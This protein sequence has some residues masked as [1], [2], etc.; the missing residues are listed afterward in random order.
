MMSFSIDF[1]SLNGSL[2]S[3]YLGRKV[4]FRLMA[5][6]NYRSTEE[7]F[8]VLLM[9]DGQDFKAMDLEK[10]IS[11]SYLNRKIRPFV[12]VGI[13]TNEN[14]LHEYGTASSGDFK[15]R[16]K[17]ANNYSKFIIE[18][19]IPFLK[20][21]FKVSHH[22]IDWVYVGMSLGGISAFDIVYNNPQYFSKVGVF[23]GSFWWRKK[24]Y[25]KNDMADRSRIIL[26]V[27][28][29]GNYSP[30]LKFWLQ[31][32]T[33]DETADRNSNGIIDAIDDTKDVVKELS[34]KGYSIPYDITYL[35][36][37]NGKHDLPTWGKVF[38]EFIKWAF[39]VKVKI[40]S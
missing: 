2:F 4:K 31:V 25:V 8:P 29:N 16:G 11:D 28:K 20:G 3:K 37:E 18:E 34:L 14:R 24:A 7:R 21:E 6:G 27:I 9:N 33:L 22:G 23:S 39:K 1:I 35:E 19:F 17:K 10:T 15:G 26:N 38:P 30:H 36:V 40:P 32:G 13:E 5:P 12:Y